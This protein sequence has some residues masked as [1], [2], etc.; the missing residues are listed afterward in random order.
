MEQKLYA[1]RK[2]YDMTQPLMPMAT[3]VWLVDNTGLTFKQVGNFCNLHELE[4][5]GIA[6]G[7]VAVHMVGQDPTANGQLSQDE[8]DRCVADPAADLV[9]N[10]DAVLVTPRTKGPRYTPVSRRSDK[11]DAI[12]WLVRYHP[13][14]KDP[15]ISRL[16]G[17][18]KNTIT[19]IRDRTHWNMTNITPKDPV[20][21][22]LCK[23]LELDAVVQKAAEKLAKE[24]PEKAAAT[25]TLAEQLDATRDI[26]ATE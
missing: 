4:V 8:I 18:T 11:P 19:K 15:Q 14:V 23:Q 12:A 13:E 7:T 3:A 16:I 2:D 21:L 20:A 10:V 22:G 24:N 6:D 1:K 9:I 26:P 25:A 5:Q 17:T